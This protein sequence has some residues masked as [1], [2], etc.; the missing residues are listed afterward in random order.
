[1]AIDNPAAVPEIDGPKFQIITKA[2]AQ[3]PAGEDGRR[4]F[5]ATASSTVIDRS[6]DEIELAALQKAAEQFRQGITIYMNH[7]FKNVESAFG[8]TDGAQLIQR[9]NDPKSGAPIW[10][11]DIEGVVNVPNPRAVQLADSIDG[12]YAKFGA[13]IT[14]YVRKHAR[15]PKTGG[16]KIADVDVVE[17][18][19]VGVP[20]NQRS[21]AQKAAIAIK[22]FG[23]DREQ[24]EE[25]LADLET[26]EIIQ[27]A[28]T[29]ESITAD[30][31]GDEVI[32]KEAEVPESESAEAPEGLDEES[33]ETGDQAAT[34]EVAAESTEGG[35]ESETETPE[36][37]PA[38]EEQAD[39]PEME[40]AA[41]FK[42]EEVAELVKQT[43]V[44]VKEIGR[45]REENATLRAQNAAQDQ[46]TM[47][48]QQEAVL[49][50]QVIDNVMKQPLRAKTAGYVEEF[51]QTSTLWAP[52]VADFL[53]KRSKLNHE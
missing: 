16:L 40:K 38:D 42:P 18:S 47:A 14:A 52:D 29:Q 45:L 41:S 1:M 24:I 25:D 20:D 48:V 23:V 36:T 9:G 35:Q 32:S 2:I 7:D 30:V 21:W 49:A 28:D 51:K 39:T 43:G 6:G 8:L 53:T 19:I 10:D 12:G 11:L 44:L 3:A 26:G 17:A 50:K 46:V 13:S 34:E 31:D 22:S 37:A 4:R 15:H 5:R 27:K 33:H